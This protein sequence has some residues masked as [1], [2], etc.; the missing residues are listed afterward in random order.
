MRQRRNLRRSRIAE[1]HLER[2]APRARF[3]QE[4][5]AD[6]TVSQRGDSHDNDQIAPPVFQM[7]RLWGRLIAP[8]RSTYVSKEQVNNLWVC[9]KCGNEF[10]ISIYLTQEVP[11]TPE[12]VD[13][14][15]PTLLVAHE[16][17]TRVVDRGFGNHSLQ[18]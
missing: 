2:I 17:R 4:D 6:P 15:F 11:L 1:K 8:E 5:G 13:T 3:L 12:V 9:P 16:G 10:E 14:F 7:C 18:C